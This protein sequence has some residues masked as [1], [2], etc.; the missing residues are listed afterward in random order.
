MTQVGESVTVFIPE[1]QGPEKCVFCEKDH[2]NEKPST[3]TFPRDMS[4]LKREGRD[5]CKQ[6]RLSRYVS[7]DAP[8]LVEWGPDI[9]IGF[10]AAAHHCIA[11]ETISKHRISGK[12]KKAGYDPNRGSNCVWLPYNR[13]QFSRARAHGKP[14][15]KH[16]GGHLDGYF[17]TVETFL[18]QVAGKVIR[19]FCTQS[20]GLDKASFDRYMLGIEGQIWVGVSRAVQDKYRLHGDGVFQ[21]CNAEWGTF[22]EENG[23]TRASFLKSSGSGTPKDNSA[24]SSSSDDPEKGAEYKD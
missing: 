15:Q 10:K 6:K 14:L 18:E 8:P 16:S 11:L 2:D 19:E 22:D 23:L 7:M 17:K 4:K 21:D 20:K 5:F 12:A 1:D 3:H 9:T 24:E 13:N